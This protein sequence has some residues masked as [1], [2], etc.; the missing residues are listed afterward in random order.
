MEV[1]KEADRP[2]LSVTVTV[3]G[4]LPLCPRAKL[5]SAPEALS[6]PHLAAILLMVEPYAPAAWV[7]TLAWLWFWT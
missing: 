5:T 7:I 3:M 6:A 4:T 1:S 2:R